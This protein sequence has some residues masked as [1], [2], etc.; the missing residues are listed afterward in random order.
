MPPKPKPF[1][2][3]LDEAAHSFFIPYPVPP[4]LK[5]GL[6]LKK[7]GGGPWST[8]ERQALARTHAKDK[9]EG[10]VTKFRC[11]K[12]NETFESSHGGRKH[13]QCSTPTS[14]AS[15]SPRLQVD[16]TFA[17]SYVSG[18]KLIMMYPGRP[19][20]CPFEQ[21]E[22]SF[23]STL[24]RAMNSMH[25][26]LFEAHGVK[27]SKFWRCSICGEEDIGLKMNGHYRRCLNNRSPTSP[28]LPSA[29][30]DAINDVQE[31]DAP[32]MDGLEAAGPT[33]P[34]SPR[35]DHIPTPIFGASPA[36]AQ[37]ALFPTGDN[38]PLTSRPAPT[39]T[40]PSPLPR[41]TMTPS[42]G[43][44]EIRVL[45]PQST[46][47]VEPPVPMNNGPDEWREV[48][49][50]F[51]VTWNQLI[52]N[53]RSLLDLEEVLGRCVVN[54][55]ALSARV[56]SGPPK[57]ETTRHRKR[58]SATSNVGEP[59]NAEEQ[60]GVSKG[61]NQ[62]RQM[63][64][65]RQQKK[66]DSKK[67]SHIQ[68]LFK[69]YPRRAVRNILDDTPPRFDGSIMAAE[70]FLRATYEKPA[71]PAEQISSSRSIF[72]ECS[73]QQLEAE[74]L[75]TLNSPPSKEEIE[76]KLRKATN[77]A[78]GNDKLEYR[79]L[80]ALDPKG[81]LLENLYAAVWRLG[82]P[83]QWK[84]SRTISIHKKGSTD[85]LGNFRPISLLPT[86]YK[87]FSAI[88][89]QRLS[90]VA[91]EKGWI[92]PSQKGFLPGVQGIQEHT[93]LLQTVV[94][95]SKATSSNMSMAWL[96]LANAFGSIHHAILKQLL[97][98][99]P[100]PAN[101]QKILMDTY[102]ENKTEFALGDD[103][104]S[105]QLT[106]GVRQGDA[107]S[108][109]IFNLAVEP[110]IRK[111]TSG[112]GFSALGV[113]VKATAYA[114]D[115]ALISSGPQELQATL[116]EV[117]ATART[118]GLEFNPAK[119]ACLFLKNGK[120]ANQK[121]TLNAVTLRCL[122]PNES[123]SYL[124]IPIGCKL[125]F[126]VPEDIVGDMDKI[127]SS[128]LAPYQKLEVYRSHL[129]PSLSHHL[130]SGRVLKDSLTV[131]DTECRKFL[132]KV[133][134]VP[135]TATIP[136]FY[137]DRNAGGLG[138]S[139]LSDDADVWTVARATQL[140]SSNDPVMKELSFNQLRCT[141]RRGLRTTITD[142]DLPISEYLSGSC[143]GGLYRL[144]F[145]PRT[146]G[147]L[148]SFSR[149]AAK[150]LGVA[151][152]VSN[153]NKIQMCVDDVAVLP[154][155][156]V[157]GLRM[158]IRGRYTKELASA[159]HQG[160]SAAGLILDDSTNDIARL[161]SVNTDLAIK[162][163]WL[164]H[165]TRLDLLPLKGY[166]W[167]SSSD[168]SCRKCKEGVE[169]AFHITNNCK[170]GLAL[171]TKRHNAILNSLAVVLTKKGLETAI[172]KSFGDTRLR[173]DLVTKALGTTYMIDVVVAF[174]DP[175]HLEE[176]YKRKKDK[177]NITSSGM[178][179]PLVVG[180]TGAWIKSNDD[181]K[182][183]LGIHAKTWTAFR[184][185]ARRLAI[186]GSMEMIRTHLQHLNGAENN[187]TNT[188][189]DEESP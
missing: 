67:S 179:L 172:D 98:S 174:D 54:W 96:D 124:G 144:R 19:S 160:K 44:N 112:N 110:L 12:C 141:I 23:T 127:A 189:E 170:V 68:Q 177:Y 4:T 69:V 136:F 178:T 99:L 148:W 166:S 20:R 119:C 30:T 157:R 40:P 120:H 161:T 109:T 100:I 7:R 114:D 49:R 168:K 149:Q 156:A 180:S 45:T 22:T 187:G 34:P 129:L 105:V 15:V 74:E 46:I 79:H 25:R 186:E 123:E 58:Q 24:S 10:T 41:E 16:S 2:L 154:A 13:N 188:D 173:P 28:A 83:K 29:R 164:L 104:V 17:P 106:A 6:C 86:M 36:P 72:D 158:A 122:E 50:R 26:H 116:S 165:K 143:E 56:V 53:S 182:T 80:R 59:V 75:E 64:R 5:C 153:A 55:K 3:V 85:D 39:A 47:I 38:T 33:S 176:A 115:I 169:N 135:S 107:L 146:I 133:A 8:E 87:I 183:L 42:L 18:N 155:K 48:V 145:A 32:S 94:E 117:V 92:S 130:A 108:T 71:P 167:S 66:F 142:E 57:P 151:V 43:G 126:R 93:Q 1:I 103:R 73:W 111:A 52:T 118:L 61:R 150:R 131:L 81:Y 147:N 128:L 159:P 51:H 97:Q 88:I 27:A 137:A 35:S 184:K 9:H 132:G 11:T 77:T 138:T 163:W 134:N 152:D 140:L 121:M 82:I 95:E 102:S 113:N 78:P 175:L 171:A 14:R 162:D 76:W 70:A 62:P 90:R 185:L 91:V 60:A 181:I 89:S 139:R 31:T 84:E 37:G 101:L 21:C 63:Q 65:A 125:R